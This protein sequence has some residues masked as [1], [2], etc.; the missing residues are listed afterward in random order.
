MYTAQ[1]QHFYDSIEE[2]LNV[3]FRAMN[4]ERS[5]ELRP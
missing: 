4:L 3:N 5:D 1:L 2:I